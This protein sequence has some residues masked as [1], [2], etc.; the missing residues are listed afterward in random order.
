MSESEAKI[1]RYL[2]KV[3]LKNSEKKEKTFDVTKINV[4][5]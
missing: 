3:Y 4:S 5:A 2:F 1:V